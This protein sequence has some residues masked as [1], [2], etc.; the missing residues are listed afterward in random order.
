MSDDAPPDPAAVADDSEALYEDAPSGALVTLADGTIVRVNRTLLRWLGRPPEDVLGRPFRELLAPGD[1]IYYETHYAPL[2]LMQHEVSGVAVT[3]VCADGS[4]VP[5]MISSML[6]PAEQDRPAAIL[7]TLFEATDRR[8]YEQE[9]LRARK[10]ARAA[11]ERA[12]ALARSLQQSLLPP[13]LPDVPGLDVAAAYHPVGQGLD[14]GGDFYDVFEMATGTWA[15]L[16]GDVSGKG[17]AAA[18]VTA[19]ARYAARGAAVRSTM[20]SDVLRAVN[21]A[22]LR[23]G[24][25]HYC[26][27]CY[28]AVRAVDEGGVRLVLSSGGHPLPLRVRRDG[29]IEGVGSPGTALGLLDEVTLHDDEV[30]LAPGDALIVYTD[31][32]TDG[33]RGDA[34]FGEERLFGALDELRGAPVSVIATSLVDRVVGFQEGWP[35]DDVAVVALMP[36]P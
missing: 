2:L 19:A 34:F 33:R 35:R 22:L 16:V 25:D 31:G 21:R 3:L 13:A 5:C 27:M 20:P 7:T 10:G 12:H 17:A 28:V 24:S 30:I 26:T 11:E 1:R 29:G 32:V 18:G 8:T 36:R 14:V 4:G 15:L 6:R 23:D 9:L